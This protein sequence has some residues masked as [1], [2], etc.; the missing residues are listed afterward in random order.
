MGTSQLLGPSVP[1]IAQE[2][3]PDA[4]KVFDGKQRRHCTVFIITGVANYLETLQGL[5]PV[6]NLHVRVPKRKM[7]HRYVCMCV[8]V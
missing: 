2:G 8:C 1:I 5:K 7:E 4:F 3:L 6:I